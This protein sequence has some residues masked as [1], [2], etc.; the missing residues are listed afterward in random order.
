[1]ENS[2]RS[3]L[4]SKLGRGFTG[5]KHL[6]VEFFSKTKEKRRTTSNLTTI[7]LYRLLVYFKVGGLKFY[8]RSSASFTVW[9][10]RYVDFYENA[11]GRKSFKKYWLGIS[12]DEFFEQRCADTC[13][14]QSSITRIDCALFFLFFFF[15]PSFLSTRKGV[16]RVYELL[17]FSLLSFSLSLSLS[18]VPWW[19]RSL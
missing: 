10:F 2:W 6:A 7:L 8:D 17:L 13:K 16:V 18:I 3:I 4:Y 9:I 19:L 12:Y 11:T 15:P 5:L 1:M 14:S